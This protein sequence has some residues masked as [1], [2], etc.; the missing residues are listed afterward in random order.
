VSNCSPEQVCAATEPLRRRPPPS[1]ASVQVSCPRSRSPCHPETAS[2]PR[3]S[4]QTSSVPRP[5]PFCWARSISQPRPSAA[6]AS[7]PLVSRRSVIG[8]L[9][10]PRIPL[11]G[12]FVNETLGFLENNPLSL[13]LARRPL[14]SSREAPELYFYLRNRSNLVF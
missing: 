6:D 3:P 4:P 2:A 10:T 9:R 5:H 1:G 7:G 13:V 14:V 11:H 12:L 8:W